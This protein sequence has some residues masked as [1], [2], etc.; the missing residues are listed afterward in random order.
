MIG[1][2]GVALG[3]AAGWLVHR[4]SLPRHTREM[5]TSGVLVL[6]IAITWATD[7]PVSRGSAGV[8]AGA[9][10]AVLATLIVRLTRGDRVAD[11]GPSARSR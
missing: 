9:A 4:T 8:A 7:G 10:I 11:S 5:V 1:L 2:L 3:L 6:G